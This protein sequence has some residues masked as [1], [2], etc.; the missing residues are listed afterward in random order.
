M[1]VKRAHLA[2]QRVI[3]ENVRPVVIRSKRPDAPRGEQVPLVLV[4]KMLA[5]LLGR[6]AHGDLAGLDVLRDS[7]LERFGDH[8]ELVPVAAEAEGQGKRKRRKSR[9]DDQSKVRA[10]GE[11]DDEEGE[12]GVAEGARY[13]LLVGRLGVDFESRRL[14]DGLPKLDDR[15]RHLDLDLRK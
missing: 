2:R 9:F 3:N 15:I 5:S 11:K 14:D 1:D 8:S 13:G 10:D 6:H 12:K 7:W 4:L